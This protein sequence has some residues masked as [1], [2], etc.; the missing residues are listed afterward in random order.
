[1]AKRGLSDAL[2]VS[3]IRGA[4]DVYGAEQ[5]QREKSKKQ[6]LEGIKELSDYAVGLAEKKE[7]EKKARTAMENSWAETIKVPENISKLSA[8]Y[9]KKAVTDFVRNA[10][11]KYS[12]LMGKYEDTKDMKYRDEAEAVLGGVVNLNNQLNGLVK[13]KA[14][15]LD[16]VKNK[17]LVALNNANIYTEAYTD[18]SQ[19]SIEENGD[20]GF[21]IS[22]GEYH[23]LNDIAGGYGKKQYIGETLLLQNSQT[24]AKD[25][26][27]G[28]EW[29]DSI[30]E[31]YRDSYTR[32]FRNMN[33]TQLQSQWHTDPTGDN[34]Y[35]I[36]TDDEGND[37]E[38]GDLS[39]NELWSTGKMDP[40]FYK[41]FKAEDGTDWIYD[42]E[43]RDELVRLQSLYFTNVNKKIAD[44]N[45]VEK[46]GGN[47]SDDSDDSDLDKFGLTPSKTYYTIQ[48]PGGSA[49]YIDGATISRT[50][51]TFKSVQD[52][53]SGVFT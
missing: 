53:G 8:D 20:V 14:S 49:S 31:S 41:N 15:F 42:P 51:E 26:A 52:K 5:Q 38:S 22:N 16:G 18:N 30:A 47:D 21:T 44:D 28:V 39:L 36:G 24:A 35:V 3:L 1:M 33:P 32:A 13:E 25:A 29:S 27:N 19:F 7:T 11:T 45:S 17:D 9:N 48:I 23:K 34:T 6:A 37:I 50:V 2:S 12:D 4:R 46:T 43:N 40:E 10:R